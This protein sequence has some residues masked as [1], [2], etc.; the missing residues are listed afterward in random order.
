MFFEQSGGQQQQVVKV[1]GSAGTQ[2][3]LVPS[4]G[5]GGKEVEVGFHVRTSVG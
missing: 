4:I 2:L 3:F 1:D 5:H